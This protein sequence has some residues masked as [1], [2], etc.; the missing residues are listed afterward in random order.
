MSLPSQLESV[1]HN[2]ARDGYIESTCCRVQATFLGLKKKTLF[3]FMVYSCYLLMFHKFS[4]L[5]MTFGCSPYHIVS[6]KVLTW[7]VI[8]D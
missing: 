1:H 6:I 4:F 8:D 5:A 7:L 2:L 3:L